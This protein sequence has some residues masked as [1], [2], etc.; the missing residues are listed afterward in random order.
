M[1]RLCPVVAGLLAWP[2][3]PASFAVGA[4]PWLDL[5]HELALLERDATVA[6]RFSRGGPS[7]EQH[8]LL[9]EALGLVVLER[10]SL[11]VRPGARQPLLRGLWCGGDVEGLSRL[12]SPFRRYRQVVEEPPASARGLPVRLR[13]LL[14]LAR[15]LGDVA[16]A[17]ER[18]LRGAANPTLAEIRQRVLT[19]CD[20]ERRLP[21]ASLFEGVLLQELGVSPARAVRAWD[22]M[23]EGGVF[24]DLEFRGDRRSG[25]PTAEVLRIDTSGWRVEQ[26]DLAAVAGG[27]E[28]V[29][30]D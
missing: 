26:V 1:P 9:A 23:V 7:A 27:A 17:G 29:R 18:P 25:A 24:E 30:R 5:L 4:R 21:V 13:T 6:L 8:L 12:L 28:L 22:R 16:V 15:R 3:F 2:E 20:P 14:S 11:L 19:A 10:R